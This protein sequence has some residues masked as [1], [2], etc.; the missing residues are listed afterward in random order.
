MPAAGPV[1]FATRILSAKQQATRDK[2][3]AALIV[4]SAKGERM[5]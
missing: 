3:L 1:F 2:R 4:A 5:P